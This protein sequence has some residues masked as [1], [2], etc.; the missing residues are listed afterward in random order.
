MQSRGDIVSVYNHINC[1]YIILTTCIYSIYLYRICLHIQ[2]IYIVYIHVH[3]H[4]HVI[5]KWLHE[6]CNRSCLGGNS[7]SINHY[8][9]ILYTG[10]VH[11]DPHTRTMYMYMNH[12]YMDIRTCTIYM[13]M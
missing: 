4:V 9:Y 8:M 2:C 6:K 12:M 11:S 1:V 10:T 7:R 5:Q 3:V 13:Y